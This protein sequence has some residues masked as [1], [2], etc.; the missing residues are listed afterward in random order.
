MSFF[1]KSFW[2][3]DAISSVSTSPL[4]ENKICLQNWRIR[5]FVIN[6]EGNACSMF[7]SLTDE[8]IENRS[9]QLNGHGGE[10]CT[11]RYTNVWRLNNHFLLWDVHCDNCMDKR[12]GKRINHLSMGNPSTKSALKF[13][14][15]PPAGWGCVGAASGCCE[16]WR[17][18]SRASNSSN[19]ICSFARFPSCL[20]CRRIAFINK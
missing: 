13:Q 18:R 7:T 2:S 16:G 8:I 10:A 9:V 17:A 14:D 11:I 3:R 1:I 12:G 4:I 20:E 6:F 15:Y 19:W 5:G